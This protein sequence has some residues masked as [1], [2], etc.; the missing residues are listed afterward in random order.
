MSW[1]TTESV[2]RTGEV[3]L[4]RGMDDA[5]FQGNPLVT[6]GHA[7]WMPPVGRSP[8]PALQTSGEQASSIS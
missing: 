2:D 1:I 8:I 5:Q 6:L 7:Y 4:A 3:V